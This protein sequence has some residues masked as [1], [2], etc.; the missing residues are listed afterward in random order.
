MNAT[1]EELEERGYYEPDSLVLSGILLRIDKVD[2]KFNNDV[3]FEG[4]KFKSGLG[5]IGVE[6][7]VH[8]KNEEWQ[9]KKSKETWFS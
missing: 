7:T 8:Y 6:I 9:I 1:I 5:A 4:S 3:L 2:Y